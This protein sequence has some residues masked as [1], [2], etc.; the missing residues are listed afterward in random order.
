MKRLE[1]AEKTY[2][3][4]Q[5][6]LRKLQN[7]LNDIEEEI[8]IIELSTSSPHMMPLYSEYNQDLLDRQTEV[9]EQKS[10]VEDT[11]KKLK[12]VHFDLIL[13]Y[14]TSQT[15]PNAKNVSNEVL[16]FLWK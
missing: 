14:F 13:E 5:H 3:K 7:D 11:R 1:Q 6:I 16:A 15:V 2:K 10:V 8:A 4:E 9:R 12:L